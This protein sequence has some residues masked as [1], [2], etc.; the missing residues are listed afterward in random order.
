MSDD[1]DATDQNARYLD[2]LV[3]QNPVLAEYSAELYLDNKLPVGTYRLLD[4]DAHVHNASIMIEEARR[5]KIHMYYMSK[6]N[7]AQ[8]DLAQAV[9]NTGF[10]GLVTVEPAELRSLSRTA[11]GWRT[12]G[13]L[14]TPPRTTSILY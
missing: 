12:W 6:Q 13:T 9:V 10:D 7:R 4:L 5:N 1:F 11:S 3:T 2:N 8:P 14:R